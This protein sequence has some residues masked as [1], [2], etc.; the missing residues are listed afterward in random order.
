M[1]AESRVKKEG[2]CYYMGIGKF[3]V[4]YIGGG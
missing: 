4:P 3:T 2:G 1:C